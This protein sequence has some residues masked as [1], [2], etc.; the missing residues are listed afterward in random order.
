MT[1]ITELNFFSIFFLILENVKF[2]NEKMEQ[3]SKNWH[4]F[5]LLDDSK[6][7]SKQNLNNTDFNNSLANPFLK[8]ILL[9]A[10]ILI[11]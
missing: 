11:M 6:A 9:N 2:T 5:L 4:L 8:P 10:S 3:K 1:T 7:L